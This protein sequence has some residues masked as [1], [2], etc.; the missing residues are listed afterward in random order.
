M[1]AAPQTTDSQATAKPAR[2]HLAKLN[3]QQRRAAERAP[4][5]EG[6]LLVIAGAGSGR[7][8]RS[9]IWWRR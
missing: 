8:T 5:A 7:R 3:P 1:S 2:A 4:A 9:P 6:P